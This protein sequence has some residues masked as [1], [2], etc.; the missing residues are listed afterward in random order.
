MIGKTTIIS[1]MQ[2]REEKPQ[3]I[4][5]KVKRRIYRRGRSSVFTAD[6]F[7]DIGNRS[8]ID[9]VLSRLAKRGTIRRLSRGL[10]LYPQININGSE[11]RPSVETIASALAEAGRMRL[12]PSGAYAANL[13]GLSEQVPMKVVFLTDGASRRV[14]VGDREIIFRRSSP[15]NMAAA[16]RLGGLVIQALRHIGPDAVDDP[17]LRRLRAAVPEEKRRHVLKDALSAPAWIRKVIW[18]AIGGDRK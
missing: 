7:A 8:S 9:L 2:G 3:L 11:A 18:D 16:G 1:I 12:Q 15:R 6:V 10:Y 5:D 17:L 14:P 13:L 4:T